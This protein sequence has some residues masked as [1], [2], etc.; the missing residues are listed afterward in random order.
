MKWADYRKMV[1]PPEYTPNCG[2]GTKR[3]SYHFLGDDLPD[4][5]PKEDKTLPAGQIKTL[6]PFAPDPTHG[7]L[8]RAH[9]SNALTPRP[10]P[11]SR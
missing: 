8:P 1:L 7:S 11:L 6:R 2:Y 3:D 5:G 4:Y 10:S 9:H